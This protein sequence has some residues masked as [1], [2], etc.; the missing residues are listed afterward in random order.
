MSARAIAFAV[1]LTLGAPVPAQA[2]EWR[3]P[4]SGPLLGRFHYGPDPFRAGQRRGI[5]I[6]APA[7][8]LVRSACAGRVVFA[9]APPH[10]GR[11]V[12]VVCGGLVATYLHLAAITV[13]AGARVSQGDRLGAVGATGLAP[14]AGPRLYLGARRRGRRLAYVDPLTLLDEPAARPPVGLP[15]GPAPRGAPL[16]PRAPVGMRRWRVP[17]STARARVPAAAWIGAALAALAVPGLGLSWRRRRRRGRTAP[18]RALA[19]R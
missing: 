1:A 19:A 5:E 11:T 15:L 4:V 8:A 14:G 3:W 17:G 18:A 2:G 7:G 12:S 9:G 6:G 13:R 10:A 16:L